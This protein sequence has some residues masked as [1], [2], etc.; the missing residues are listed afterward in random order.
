MPATAKHVLLSSALMEHIAAYQP[1]D[2]TDMRPFR[3]VGYEDFKSESELSGLGFSDANVHANTAPN[4]TNECETDRGRVQAHLSRCKHEIARPIFDA[5]YAQYG[6]TRVSIFV[7][8]WCGG[9]AADL[10]IFDAIYYARLDVLDCL[11]QLSRLG[12][13]SVPLIDL[14]AASGQVSALQFLFEYGYGG[15]TTFTMDDAARNGHLKVVQWLHEHSKVGCSFRAIDGAAAFGHLDVVKFLL[16]ARNEGFS[17]GAIRGAASIG[18]LTLVTLLADESGVEDVL[19]EAMVAAAGANQ[20][21][22]V[23]FCYERHVGCCVGDAFE[24]AA[25]LC[26]LDVICYLKQRRCSC[27]PWGVPDV[28]IAGRKIVRPKKRAAVVA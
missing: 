4:D 14:A 15:C 1:S 8:L 13:S 27:C 6:T 12:G 3:V 28:I 17:I 19:L 24:A 7:R 9:G 26:Q 11:H 10:L 21:H 20:L 23:T 22:V 5:W 2:Y 16:D 25:K 18:H